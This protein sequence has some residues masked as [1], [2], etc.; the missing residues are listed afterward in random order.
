VTYLLHNGLVVFLAFVV[1]MA[2]GAWSIGRALAATWRPPWQGAPYSVML[3]LAGRLIFWGLSGGNNEQFFEGFS[4][5]YVDFAVLI[6]VA[7]LAYRLTKTRKM[8]T[9]Y[10]WLYEPVGPLGWRERPPSSTE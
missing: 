5:I 4:D 7:L 2:A 3:G 6:G 9:Q 10:P 1:I 8:V